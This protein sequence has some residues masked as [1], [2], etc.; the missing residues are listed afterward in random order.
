[1]TTVT[2]SRADA[3]SIDARVMNY[4]ECELADAI[5]LPQRR[6]ER[7]AARASHRFGLRAFLPRRR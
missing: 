6:R 1:M 3:L 7:S 5:T 2:I 4:V